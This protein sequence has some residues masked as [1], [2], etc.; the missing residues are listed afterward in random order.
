MES[1]SFTAGTRSNA[2]A[3][4]VRVHIPHS[5]TSSQM[6]THTVLGASAVA[7]GVKLVPVA[8]AIT[9]IPLMPS[10]RK[11]HT[12]RS[13]HGIRCKCRRRRRA[14]RRANP[15]SSRLGVHIESAHTHPTHAEGV[16]LA[17]VAVAIAGRDVRT[18]TLVDLAG[19][20]ANAAGV[21]DA[22]VYVVA[23]PAI[24]DIVKRAC[25][26]SGLVGLVAQM[27]SPSAVH[28]PHTPKASNW[29]PLQSQS[30][31]GMRPAL[32]NLARTVADATGVQRTHALV[33][34]VADAVAIG[35]SSASAATH[36]QGV[37]LAAVA[38]AVAGRMFAHP[39]S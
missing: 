12:R 8:I 30:P 15:R 19:T 5:S 17:A 23:M 32:V 9:A 11:P 4:V 25:R 2:V 27:P 28:P 31:A 34:V 29:L 7:E 6:P 3:V 22:L 20:V 36:A 26:P 35:V 10:F 39:H 37:K 21:T 1:T 13:R 38:I 33:H 16:K 14:Y 24:A 18:H